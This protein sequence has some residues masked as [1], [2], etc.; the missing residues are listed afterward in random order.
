MKLYSDYGGRRTRQISFDVIAVVLIAGWVWLGVSLYALVMN[1]AAFGMQMEEAGAGFKQTMVE[2]G[3]NLGGVPLIGGGIRL[4][5]DGASQAGAALEEAG[6]SQQEAVTQL[7]TVLGV[8]IAALPIL[9]ILLLWLIP[10]LRFVRKASS[11]KSLVSSGDGVDLLALRAL[12]G[13]KL[14]KLT[15]IDPDPVAAWRRGD[16]EVMQQLAQLELRSSGVRLS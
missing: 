10:R 4:P 5:F 15:T 13:Q 8:G 14:S 1:L 3:D 11:A 7:A 2:V 6:Q 16:R 12:A 9:T